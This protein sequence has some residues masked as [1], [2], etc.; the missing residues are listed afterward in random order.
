MILAEVV[1]V[2]ALVAVA[3]SVVGAAARPAVAV[4]E[5][6]A[7]DAAPADSAAMPDIPSITGQASRGPLPGLN[8]SPSFW[9]ARL[10]ELNRDEVWMAQ[11]QW[12]IVHAAMGAA[13]DYVE[14]VVLPA[15]RRAEGAALG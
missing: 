3:W 7:P 5:V 14:K 8:L 12:R 1:V 11:V 4:P 6:A 9:R 10:A 13:R 15:V 2:G